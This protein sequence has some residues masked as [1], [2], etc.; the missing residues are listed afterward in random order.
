MGKNNKRAMKQAAKNEQTADVLTTPVSEET[1]AAEIPVSPVQE[2][3]PDAVAPAIKRKG[4]RKAKAE[5]SEAEQSAPKRAHKTRVGKLAAELSPIKHKRKEKTE[6]PAN[7]EESVF[8]QYDGQELNIAE[9]KERIIAA[10]VEAGHRRG[11]ISKL[12]LYI[13]P[14]DHKAYY[15]INDKI[16]GSVDF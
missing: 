1:Q 16:S 7:A 10:Y 8:L 13:K 6:I 9:L 11:R 12:N 4:G 3:A 14:E 15:V 2:S 5:K